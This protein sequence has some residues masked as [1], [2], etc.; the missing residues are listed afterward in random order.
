MEPR[1]DKQVIQM[2][3]PASSNVASMSQTIWIKPSQNQNPPKPENPI[4]KHTVIGLR[5]VI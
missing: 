1:L 2:T 3:V 4:P 5:T